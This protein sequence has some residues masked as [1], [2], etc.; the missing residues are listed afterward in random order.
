M[1][2]LPQLPVGMVFSSSQDRSLDYINCSKTEGDMTLAIIQLDAEEDAPG[3]TLGEYSNLFYKGAPAS[4]PL[5]LDYNTHM[6]P[7]K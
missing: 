1:L 5:Y 4:A 7:D 2:R 6:L 3:S